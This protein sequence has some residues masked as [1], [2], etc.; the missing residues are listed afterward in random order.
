[1]PAATATATAT[2]MQAAGQQRYAANYL[3]VCASVS[4]C[5][6]VCVR[7]MQ[8]TV[9]SCGREQPSIKLCR[10]VASLCVCVCA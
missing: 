2:A 9:A 10:W 8:I 5:C 7:Y 3:C 4:M 1:M 6:N